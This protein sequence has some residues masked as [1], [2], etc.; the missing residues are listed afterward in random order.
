M[1]ISI[2]YRSFMRLKWKRWKNS[3]QESRNVSHFIL[4]K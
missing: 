2:G 1:G 4:K 3:V